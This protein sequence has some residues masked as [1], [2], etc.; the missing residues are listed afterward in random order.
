MKSIIPRLSPN[1]SFLG[2]LAGLMLFCALMIGIGVWL[3]NTQCFAMAAI[4]AA[5]IL[6]LTKF[7]NFNISLLIYVLML[8]MVYYLFEFKLQIHL[9]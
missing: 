6:V 2:M 9:I 7:D 5:Y 3:N 1:A 4:S 8:A